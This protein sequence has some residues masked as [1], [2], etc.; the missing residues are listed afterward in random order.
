MSPLFYHQGELTISSAME[1]LM[2]SLFLDKVPDTWQRYPSSLGLGA[3]FSDLLLRSRELEMWAVDFTLPSS[4]SRV[5]VFVFF[6][7]CF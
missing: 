7:F 1:D 2:N 3:W 5:L 6:T 4:V